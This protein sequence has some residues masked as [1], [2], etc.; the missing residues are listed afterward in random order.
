MILVRFK[1]E[2]AGCKKADQIINQ[3][4][5]ADDLVL[6]C[7]SQRGLYNLLSIYEKYPSR[8]DIKFNAK[9]IVVGIRKS[10][11]LK[12]TIVSPFYLCNEKLTVVQN[13][14]Y[15][16][17]YITADGKYNVDIN[18]AC[19]QLYVHGN[20]LIRKLCMFPENLL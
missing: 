11:V 17:H 15:V 9:K 18:R 1:Q 8:H 13:T 6:M 4:F 5:Y 2:Y 3:L 12:N 16:G 10:N 19:R 20:S 7:P 14:K